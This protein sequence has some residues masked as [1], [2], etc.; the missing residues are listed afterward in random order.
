M[1]AAVAARAAALLRG[2]MSSAQ[3]IR[4]VG[5]EIQ[6]PETRDLIAEVGHGASVGAALSRLDGPEWRVLGAAWL[7]AE[8]SGAALAPA[9]DRIAAA[10]DSI[11]EA[12]RRRSV[13]LAG[14]KM[15]ATL[16]GWLPLAS[17]AVSFLLGFNPFPLFITPIGALLLLIGLVLQIVGA[18]WSAALTGRVEREDRVAGLECE[19]M[20]VALAGGAPP[21]L[22][23][24][25]VADAVS[26]TRAE[27]VTFDS[28]RAGRPLARV[29]EVAA[30]AGVPTSAM[31]LDEAN[32]IRAR[33]QAAIER[34]AERLGIRILFPLASC[35]LPAFIAVGVLPVV[36]TLLGDVLPR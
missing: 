10:L 2:G 13:L 28:L 3:A 18:R 12:N 27:W 23:L 15:T 7:L 33:G 36:V 16:V 32:Q 22:A 21:G 34:E 26:E 35:Q 25:R 24:R 30:A 31:L 6:R 17:I 1:P 20:W 19:L 5:E 8:E 29:L 9:L 14:P 4:S 11:S